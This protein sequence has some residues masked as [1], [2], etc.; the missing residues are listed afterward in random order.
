MKTTFSGDDVDRRKILML[1]GLTG[2]VGWRLAN[3]ES[4]P[5]PAAGVIRYQVQP[6]DR[7]WRA[8]SH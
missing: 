2:V 7:V 8:P 6:V 4:S 3:Q 5:A 1:L